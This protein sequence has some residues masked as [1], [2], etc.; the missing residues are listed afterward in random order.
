MGEQN[1]LDG[2]RTNEKC[3]K[4]NLELLRGNKE[5]SRGDIETE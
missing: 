5:D 4:A 3:V 2:I 1:W